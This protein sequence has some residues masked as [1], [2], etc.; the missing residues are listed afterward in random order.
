MKYIKL[1][2]GKVVLVDDEDF[3]KL[4]QYKWRL[5]KRGKT[6]YAQTRFPNSVQILMHRFLM[7]TPQGMETDH[8]DGDGLNNQ[9]NNLR[10]CTHREN[11]MNQRKRQGT[12]KY[13]GVYFRKDR[14]KWTTRIKVNGRTIHLGNFFEE[15][16]AAMAYNAAAYIY[17]RNFAKL[18]KI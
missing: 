8:I 12:S 2:Q 11:S 4:N 14:K 1:T 10:I 5:A 6:I 3:E 13:K 15:D 16:K 17:Y 9:R 7:N 18:N